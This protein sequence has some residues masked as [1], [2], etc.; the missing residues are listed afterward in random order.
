MSK[1]R[2]YDSSQEGPPSPVERVT[3]CC[4]RKLDNSLPQRIVVLFSRTY[5]FFS[6]KAVR[7]NWAGFPV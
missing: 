2:C 6:V 1:N 7:L 4:T 3:Q 5:D